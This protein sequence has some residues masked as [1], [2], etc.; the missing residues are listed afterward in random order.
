MHRKCRPRAYFTHDRFFDQQRQRATERREH[1]GL[2][3]ARWIKVR[4]GEH[5]EHAARFGRERVNRRANLLLLGL[6]LLIRRNQPV[7]ALDNLL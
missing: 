3:P 5:G 2:L 6:I 1:S 7:G 4:I